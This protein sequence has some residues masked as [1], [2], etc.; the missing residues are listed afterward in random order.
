MIKVSI[1]MPA[2]NCD[3]TIKKTIDSVLSQEFDSYELIIVNDGSKDNT[4]TICDSIS[5]PRVRVIN[6]KNQGPS[7]ARNNGL[8][9]AKGKYVMFI[10]ADD[11]YFPDAIK[12]M[13]NAIES[14]NSD[15]LTASYQS[16]S[17]GKVYSPVLIKKIENIR[18][19]EKYI[20]YL[21]KCNV[22]NSNWNKI[23]RRDIICKNNV[24]FDESKEIGEDVRFNFEYLK[25]CTSYSTIDNIVYKYYIND[26]GLTHKNKDTKSTRILNF[27]MYQKEYYDSLSL[28][29][30]KFQ[31]IVFKNFVHICDND[32]NCHGYYKLIRSFTNKI[33]RLR[34]ME[35]LLKSN[36]KRMLNLLISVYKKVR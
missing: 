35:I 10:D 8:N 30:S 13:Y 15:I 24:L 28:D 22:L 33:F 14:F 11:L 9:Y 29:T 1:I 32:T 20:Y 19:K 34:V 5:D 2:Y 25:Y 7:A 16:F 21:Q 17:D 31:R 18:S 36:K 27:L 3:K 4:K 12:T 23:Y 26:S 6:Q